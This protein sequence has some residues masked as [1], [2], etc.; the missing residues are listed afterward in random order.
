MFRDDEITHFIMA[1]DALIRNP[2][3]RHIFTISAA[4]G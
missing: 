1:R 2:P 3:F 4:I